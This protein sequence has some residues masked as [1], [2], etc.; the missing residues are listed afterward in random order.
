MAITTIADLQIVRRISCAKTGTGT[1]GGRDDP[2]T[3]TQTG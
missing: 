1:M 2:D 3:P